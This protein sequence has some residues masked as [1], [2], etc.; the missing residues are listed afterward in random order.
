MNA[1]G[2]D[3]HVAALAGAIG[4]ASGNFGR[5]LREADALSTDLYRLRIAGPCCVEENLLKSGAVQ[6]D[7][8]GARYLAQCREIYA[9]KYFPSRK[10]CSRPFNHRSGLQSRFLQTEA[11]QRDHR[12][13]PQRQP[14]PDLGDLRYFL[15]DR[16]LD[17]D[18]LERDCGSK[19]ANA[20]AYDQCANGRLP[21]HA[22]PTTSPP[23]MLTALGGPTELGRNSRA[24]TE[25][26][27]SVNLGRKPKLTP[28]RRKSD[29]T[30]RGN[31]PRYDF[32]IS[33]AWLD[34]QPP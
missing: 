33:R 2:T 32:E 4:E 31:H 20:A 24:P 15:E 19:S 10:K 13:G 6:A 29:R 8:S 34:C 14:G 21:I 25:D 11:P 26:A 7:G 18:T 28:R 9:P 30:L 23:L 12:I 1:V 27:R 16:G 22:D 5:I 3:Q 17:P